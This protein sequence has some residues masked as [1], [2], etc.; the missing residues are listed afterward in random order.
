VIGPSTYSRAINELPVLLQGDL[1]GALLRYR[2]LAYAVGVG[3]LLLVVVGM[4]LQYGASFDGVVAVI[5]PIHGV[6]YIIYLIASLDLARRARFSLLQLAG[7]VGAGFLPG[8]AFVAEHSVRGRVESKL[9]AV[10][11]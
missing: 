2:I 11:G 7:M 3:L 10:G 4:P 8:L 6:L 1:R 5:G 9:A